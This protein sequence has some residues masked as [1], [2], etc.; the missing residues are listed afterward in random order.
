MTSENNDINFLLKD[1]PENLILRFG[2]IAEKIETYNSFNK[3]IKLEGLINFDFNIDTNT[4]EFDNVLKLLI[5]NYFEDSICEMFP[6]NSFSACLNEFKGQLLIPD[7]NNSSTNKT[8]Y[9]KV[10]H[11]E[12]RITFRQRI[13]RK[14]DLSM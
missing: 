13:F 9:R 10:D 8:D 5:G 14:L 4:P 6:Q 3:N 12:F 7:L 11:K 2:N 1:I